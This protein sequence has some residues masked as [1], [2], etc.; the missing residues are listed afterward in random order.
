MDTRMFAK[1]LTNLHKFY[2]NSQTN[3]HTCLPKFAN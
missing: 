2:K 1:I 3:L